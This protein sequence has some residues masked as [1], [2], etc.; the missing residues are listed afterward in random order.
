[1]VH[2]LVPTLEVAEAHV[3]K[4]AA[5]LGFTPE[6]YRQVKPKL[7]RPKCRSSTPTDSDSLDGGVGL[8][9]K[10]KRRGDDVDE[11]RSSIREP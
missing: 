3:A 11:E 2:P 1:M 4:L 10:R 9:R 5:S 6:G 7:G 8:H